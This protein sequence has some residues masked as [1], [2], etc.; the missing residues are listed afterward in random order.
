MKKLYVAI[1]LA[2]LTLG[3]SF[4]QNTF[5]ISTPLVGNADL[6]TPAGTDVTGDTAEYFNSGLINLITAPLIIVNPTASSITVKIRRT[7][8]S[9][10]SGSSNYFC[11][12]L[13][14]SPAT[15]VSS[16]TVTIAA[17]DTATVFYADYDPQGNGGTSY[18]KYKFFNATDSTQYSSATIKYTSGT[19]GIEDE[20]VSLSKVYPNPAT[21]FIIFDYNVG[22]SDGTITIADLTGKI[23]KTIVVGAGTNK[24]TINLDGLTNGV[25]IYAFH[26]NGKAIA[27]KKFIIKK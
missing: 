3:T 25:Y 21:D 20:E 1:V 10:I 5:I 12:D 11:W 26:V 24:Q 27:T 6:V 22:T 19:I 15:S 16:G 17:G 7:Q 23:V 14:Y 9:L 18:I 8:L 13:C 2:T 4:A